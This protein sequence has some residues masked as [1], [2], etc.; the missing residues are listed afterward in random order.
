[1]PHSHH[2]LADDFAVCVGS[3]YS[4]L[5]NTSVEMV[6][7]SLNTTDWN[8]IASSL[9]LPGFALCC[10]L[11]PLPGMAVVVLEAQASL[12]LLGA[13][14]ADR[15]EQLRSLDRQFTTFEQRLLRRNT[16]PLLQALAGAFRSW[17]QTLQ[18]ML[19]TAAAL[20]PDGWR[21][22]SPDEKGLHVTYQLHVQYA[23]GDMHLFLPLKLL[24]PLQ[25]RFEQ[26]A[27]PLLPPKEQRATSLP[28][29]F[30]DLAPEEQIAA[31]FAESPETRA[32]SLRGMSAQ[33]RD[34]LLENVSAEQRAKLLKDIEASLQPAAAP[35][36]PLE[37][38]D[39]LA[40]VFMALGETFLRQMLPLLTP[41]AAGGVL[42]AMHALG[43]ISQ[44]SLEATLQ[45]Q[46][47]KLQAAGP[48][49][50]PDA[51]RLQT[52]LA[53]TFGQEQ[54]AQL[55]S[56]EAPFF[57]HL[58]GLRRLTAEQV[59]DAARLELPQTVAILCSQ[60]QP[61][62][63]AAYLMEVPE[64]ERIEAMIR[65]AAMSSVPRQALE[66]LA[67]VLMESADKDLSPS[68]SGESQARFTPRFG[69]AAIVDILKAM[70]PASRE[71]MLF[72]LEEQEALIGMELQGWEEI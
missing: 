44:E 13:A 24:E 54:A 43:G 26:P 62:V 72:L 19:E 53:Q 64:Q 42:Q 56:A 28:E 46:G 61:K 38:R 57:A 68:D 23:T 36:V 51:S 34:H 7:I 22:S 60:L 55:W 12:A 70:D 41:E 21:P 50:A 16:A 66:D 3:T 17:D 29:R 65:L 15:G 1:M 8:N 52:L 45:E 27:A 40:A 6:K 58:S 2:I 39:A 32:A 14:L 10:K 63:A 35:V 33:L 4:R 37:G 30:Q 59:T 5:L 25:Q 49:V 11:L 9:P 31:L 69:L 47:A 48:A 20:E 67:A 71:E 18:P